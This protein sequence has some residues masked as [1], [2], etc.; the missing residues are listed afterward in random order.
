M[1]TASRVRYIKLGRGGSWEDD[2]IETNTIRLGFGTREHFELCASG[3]W[4]ELGAK[5]AAEGRS[6]GKVTETV[7][8]IRTFFEDDGSILWITFSRRLMWWARADPDTSIYPHSEDGT[9]RPVLGAWRS[10]DERGQ[11]L[12]MDALSGAVTQLASYRGTSCDVSTPE[13][14]LLRVSGKRLA[15]V[16]KAERLTAELSATIIEVMRLLTPKDFELLVDLV[17]SESGWRRLGVLGKTEKTVDMEL[18]LPTTRERAFV[19]VKSR[20][21]Q[22]EFDEE[23]AEAFHAMKQVERMFYV[24]HTGT[25][26]SADPAITL[27]GPQELSH[28]VLDAGLASWLLRRVG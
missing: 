21:S 26:T 1:V 15:V 18:E 20:A 3:K 17:F 6:Q 10:T 4:L 8:Q 5:Y 12:H 11:T 9:F 23:Y 22:R 13:Y 14:V 27:I 28:M 24:Y 19:Q 25:I 7:N 2:C 16:S